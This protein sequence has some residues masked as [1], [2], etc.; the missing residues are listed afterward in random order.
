MPGA[1][2]AVA[3]SNLVLHTKEETEIRLADKRA[4]PL[5]LEIGMGKG[6]FIIQSAALHPEIQYLGIEMYESVMIRAIQKLKRME[7]TPDG[8]PDNLRL[9]RMDAREICDW[10]PAESVDRIYLNF[11]DPWP[12]VRH[13]KRRLPSREFLN[14]FR[15]ILKLGSVIE[16][17]TDNRD[18][19]DFAMGEYEPAG[20][21]LLYFTYDLH[22]D[23]EA[24]KTNIMTEYE[25]KFSLKGNP[26]CKYIIEKK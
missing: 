20:F 1:K 14:R 7:K 4:V 19:F 3:E 8:R 16:F 26:I 22:S 15:A 9:I 21:S 23:T 6:Q 5:F 25:E 17:K 24:M 12:K 18:L 10:F 2:E 13:A 11:S